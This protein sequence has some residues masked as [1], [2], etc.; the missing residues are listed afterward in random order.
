MSVT[1]G[2]CF[3]CFTG[4]E[5]GFCTGFSSWAYSTSR[6]LEHIWLQMEF[7]HQLDEPASSNPPTHQP[8]VSY[9]YYLSGFIICVDE[10]DYHKCLLFYTYFPQSGDCDRTLRSDC[11]PRRS[12]TRKKDFVSFNSKKAKGQFSGGTDDLAFSYFSYFLVRWLQHGAERK[13]CGRISFGGL[14]VLGIVP[15]LAIKNVPSA[16]VQGERRSAL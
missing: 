9:Y 2:C 15:Q 11:V 4:R 8:C 10:H 5:K 7:N 6:F 13:I 12:V 1:P 16:F 14:W 3:C